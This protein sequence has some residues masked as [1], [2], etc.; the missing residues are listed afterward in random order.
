MATAL[1]TTETL[2]VASDE[3]LDTPV[4]VVD[5]ALLQRN[6]AEMQALAN[7]H[8]VSL[9]PH[10]KTHKSPRIGQ[11]QVAAGAAG[12]S[13]AKLGEA[14]VFAREGGIDDILIAYPIVGEEKIERLLTLMEQTH[15]TVAID[16]LAAAQALS[17]ALSAHG[18]TL[19]LYLEV[20]TGMNRAGVEPGAEAVALAIAINRLPGLRLTGVMTF[21]GHA[22]TSPPE[23]IAQVSQAAGE[24]IV[25]T[26]EQIRA[27]GIPIQHVSVGSTPAAWFTP[28][29]PGVTE[30]RPGTYV[31][32]DN[33]AFR[34]S[35]IGPE[36][37]AARIL[38]TVVSRPAADRAVIDAGSKALA[39]DPSPSHPGYG[40]IVGHP[41][42]IIARLSEEHGVVELPS[43]VPGFA[44]G[45]RI[46]IIANHI[47]PAINLTD[48]LIILEEG[49]VIDR[50]P[51]SA[52][53]KVR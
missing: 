30:M 4:M 9:R 5:R 1:G 51:V 12:L 26:A 33:N 29:V 7:S 22:G 34:H 3:P 18:K 11:M 40:Y 6:I 2:L 17:R 28:A 8:G 52:R 48:E 41:E 21:E 23:T 39:L 19:D 47:C 44:V 53:G 35:R 10:A 42:A 43:G 15:L 31:F 45:D 25:A 16:T 20:N 13:C 14:E 49:R 32:Q 50:W 46:E 36:R 27:A 38:A 37:C 24:T